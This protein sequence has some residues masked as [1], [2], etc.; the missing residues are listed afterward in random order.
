MQEGLTTPSNGVGERDDM[1]LAATVIVQGWAMLKGKRILLGARRALDLTTLHLT[2]VIRAPSQKQTLG[3]LSQTKCSK[4]RLQRL[5]MIPTCLSLWTTLGKTWP[6]LMSLQTLRAVNCTWTFCR[7]WSKTTI[8]RLGMP[9]GG[10]TENLF[11][12]EAPESTEAPEAPKPIAP[13]TRSRNTTE[14]PN[15]FQLCSRRPEPY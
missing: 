14:T 4:K 5:L 3:Q 7:I 15:R 8:H 10:V 1:A 9:R 13:T 12:P 11:H 2:P 6:L